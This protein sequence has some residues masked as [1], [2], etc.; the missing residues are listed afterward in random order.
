[1]K[2]HKASAGPGC[3]YTTHTALL[4]YHCQTSQ[5]TCLYRRLADLSSGAVRGAEWVGRSLSDTVF[6]NSGKEGNVLFNDAL[7]TFYLS[8]SNKLIHVFVSPSRRPLV[9]G[10][11]RGRVGGEVI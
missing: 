8:L 10:G 4:A 2:G 3:L 6:K 5:S 11:S 9:R 1:M 7:N